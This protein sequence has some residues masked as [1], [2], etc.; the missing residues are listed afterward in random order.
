MPWELALAV[1]PAAPQPIFLQIARALADDIRRGRLR[2]GAELPGSRAL[3]RSL[4]VHR[5]TVLAAYR[6]GDSPAN[7]VTPLMAYFPL[8]VVFV[9]RYKKEAGI[10]SVVALM[11][12]YVAVLTVAWILFFVAW[13]LIGIPLGPGAPVHVD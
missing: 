6:V 12:P 7:V 3:A 2:A 4:S 13:Y 9:Q 1:D 11:L 5:N 8:V 10:G